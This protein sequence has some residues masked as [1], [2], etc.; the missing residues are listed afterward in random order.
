[1]E[2]YNY[3]GLATFNVSANTCEFK[4]NA[5]VSVDDSERCSIMNL[6]KTLSHH[7]EFKLHNIHTLAETG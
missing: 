3:F 7:K 4:F 1:M 5:S 2:L 6:F